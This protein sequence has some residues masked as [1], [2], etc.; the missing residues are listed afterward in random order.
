MTRKDE[1]LIAFDDAQTH[2]W[3]SIEYA[4]KDL[5]DEE[6]L[7][8]H[9]AYGDVTPEGGHPPAGTALWHLV[10]LQNCYDYYNLGIRS[11]PNK[12]EEIGTTGAATVAEAVAKLK[13]SRNELRR[14]VA[15][16]SEEQ[17]DEALGSGRTVIELVR[18]SI[19]HDAW[20]SGQVVMSRRL[21]QNRG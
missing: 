11:R 19:R 6:A 2:A 5:T 13:W 18:A 4:I 1:L 20:H 14:S 10:H 3:E 7:Y 12:P 8:Q 15:A 17:L 9:P 16:L 21:W